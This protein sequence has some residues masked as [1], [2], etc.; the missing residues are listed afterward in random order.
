MIPP[1]PLWLPPAICIGIG[2]P[3]LNTFQYSI[4]RTSGDRRFIENQISKE[5][6]DFYS[7]L[8]F[9]IKF[10]EEPNYFRIYY[11]LDNTCIPVKLN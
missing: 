8:I 2:I 11:S 10:S 9:V 4:F 1:M 6:F 5:K 7:G 3:R